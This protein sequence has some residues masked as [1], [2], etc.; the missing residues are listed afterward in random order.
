MTYSAIPS[1]IKPSPVNTQISDSL[2]RLRQLNQQDV[3]G[4]WRSYRG[5]LTLAQATSGW[6]MWARIAPNSNN[7]I[8][9]PR[10]RTVLWLAQRILVPHN[11]QGYFLQGLTLRV[12]LTWWAA[13]AQIYVNG[14]LVQEGDL[15]DSTT[16]ILLLPQVRIGDTVDLLLRLESPGHA[17]GA[18]TRALC[19]Y[20]L[21]SQAVNPTAEPAFV[22]DELGVLQ[23]FLNAQAPDR[24]PDLAAAL[25]SLPWSVLTVT[26]RASFDRGLASLRERLKPLSSIAKQR[27][28]QLLGNAHLD[29]AWLW[30]ISETWQVAER[31]FRSVLDLQKDFPE[32]TF[33]HTSPALYAWMEQNRPE[34]FAA[35]QAKVRAGSWDV[36][37]GPLWIEPDM[38]LNSGEAIGRHLLYG[39]RYLQQKFGQTGAIAWLP[40]TFGF[41][42]Q[43]PQLLK[44]GGVEYFATQKLRWNDTTRFPHELH[45]WQAADGTQV[46]ALHSAPI[47]EGIDPVKMAR[48]SCDWETR[49]GLKFALWLPGVGDHG[50]GPTRD[51]LEL[52]RRWQQSPFFPQIQFTSAKAF[53]DAAKASPRPAPL[54]VWNSEIYLELHRGCYINRAD[55]KQFNRRCEDTLYEA[56]LFASLSSLLTGAPYPKA[57]LETA[58]KQVLLNQFHDILPGTSV[59]Q[60]FVDANRDWQAALDAAWNVRQQAMQSIVAQVQRPAPPHPQARLVAV[61]N[62]LGWLRSEVTLVTTEQSQDERACF[63][64][65]TDL[66]GREI[67]SQ[68]HCWRE[69]GKTYCQIFFRTDSIPAIGYRCYWLTPRQTGN[70]VPAVPAPGAPTSFVLENERLRATIDPTTGNLATLFDKLYRRDLLSRGSNELQAFRDSGQYWDAWDIAPNYAQFPL[71]PAQL[72]QIF[73]EDRGPITTKIRVVRRI[74]QSTFNQVYSLDQGA[75]VLQIDNQV[76]WRERQVLVKAAFNFN[77]NASVASYEIACGAIQ[78]TTSPQ[79]P[80][81]R[82]KWEV[83]ALRWA[84][85]SD[86]ATGNSFGVSILS[87]CKQGYDA[88][89][90]QLRLSL[91]RGSLWPDPN[92]DLDQHQFTYAVYSHDRDWKAGQT[93]RRAA[94]LNQPLRLLTLNP[95]SL[96]GPAKLPP[97]GEFLSLPANF[98][99]TA[100]KPSE[101]NPNQWILRGYECHGSSGQLN[102]Q[103]GLG[104]TLKQVLNPSATRLNLLEQPTS[105]AVG[106]ISPWQI[107]TYGFNKV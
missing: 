77:I 83:P 7:Q 27:Q 6:Q 31:T 11:L 64:Q 43:L 58:W 101:D 48:Y 28:L 17:D 75:A 103:N 10:G 79:T 91:L 63:W 4:N 84:D 104:T 90:N 69:G 25:N 87:D 30:P 102:W 44:Q 46:L 88:R 33:N 39:Q 54:P 47:G 86:S 8:T 67:P 32:L 21:A 68:P 24:L 66:S 71:P 70:P 5:N 9:W 14:R 49:T 38:N 97:V 95:A 74:G 100:F 61:F 16:R 12:A 42:W 96:T 19:L 78:R 107:A 82:A 94:E 72:V 35:I 59:P 23:E 65:I 89:P 13:D 99:L 2:R 37:V 73:Y 3:Q 80:A 76:D 26:D 18:L 57:R 92:S 29:M 98:M 22:A 105:E 50:G 15:F 106:P 53:L 52:A 51:M 55:Q 41:N 34:L 60:V 40:D 85:L 45:Q 56:E 81:E 1:A 93:V 20:E 36:S 62:P